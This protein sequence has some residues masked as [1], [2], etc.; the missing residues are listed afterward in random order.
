[1]GTYVYVNTLGSVPRFS[2]I[3]T[4]YLKNILF[5][6]IYLLKIV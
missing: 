4:K 6:E 2:V 3:D 1:M 5:Y